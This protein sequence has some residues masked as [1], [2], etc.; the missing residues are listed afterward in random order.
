MAMHVT[1]AS[2][3]HQVNVCSPSLYNDDDD[4]NDVDDDDDDNDDND[5]NFE[6]D[7]GH[8]L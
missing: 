4:D 1:G 6:G 8:I 3:G 5:D 2:C 7:K